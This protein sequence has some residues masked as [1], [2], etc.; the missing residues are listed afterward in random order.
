MLDQ[1]NIPRHVAIIIDGNGRWAKE[2]GLPRIAGHRVGINRVREI[3]KA[4]GNLGIKVISFFVFSAENWVRPKKEVDMLMRFLN[5]FLSREIKKL[6]KNNIKFRWIGR[7]K[8]IPKELQAKIR[9]AEEKTR[10]NTGLVLLLALNYGARQEIIEAV[11]KFTQQVL[12]GKANLEDLDVESFSNYLYT[13]GLP[14]PDL[15][16]RTSGEM[17]LSNF[18]LWQLSYTELYF[19]KKYWPDFKRQDLEEAIRVYQKRQRRFGGID[20]QEKR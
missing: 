11:R 15:L 4:A 20:S 17:R 5:H 9:E 13:R 8:P 1:N 2:K 19:P 18:L 12:E 3:I 7:A 10:G 14:D 6:D 16:I